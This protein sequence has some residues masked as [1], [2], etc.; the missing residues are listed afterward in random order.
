MIESFDTSKLSDD[1]F[2]VLVNDND[3][4]L[5]N[6]ET[7]PDGVRFR[8][9]F[10]LN[11]IAK[12]DLFVP[13]G[14]RPES[15]NASNVSMLFDSETGEPNYKYIVEGANLFITEDARSTLEAANVVLFKDAS[16]NKGGV[17]SSSLEVLA[18]LALTDE[19]FDEHMRVPNNVAEDAPQFYQDYVQEITEIVKNNARQEF[20]VLW[21]EHAKTGIPRHRLTDMVSGRINELNVNVQTSSLWENLDIRR[22]VLAKALPNKLQELVGLDTLLERLPESY[23]QAV[24]GYYIA[25]SYVYENGM[26]RS[27]AEFSFFEYMKNF[28]DK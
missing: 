14:G 8:N 17:T 11:P 15:I 4:L 6:G 27:G 2:R 21:S 20:E 12:S 25:S 28:T 16:T 9:S 19:E 22:K 23:Q 26:P 5:P 3:I 10:H 7:V 13:C 24:F 18:A 1:G